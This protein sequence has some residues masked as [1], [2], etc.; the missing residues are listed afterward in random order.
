MI[1]LPLF[2]FPPVKHC[3]NLSLLKGNPQSNLL[4]LDMTMTMYLIV[5]LFLIQMILYPPFLCQILMMTDLSK[6]LFS[7]CLLL[8]HSAQE[9]HPTY[10]LILYSIEKNCSSLKNLYKILNEYKSSKIM[11][12]VLEIATKLMEIVKFMHLNFER[13]IILQ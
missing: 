7:A 12:L 6:C 10:L 5:S 3:A 4:R 13:L 2:I 9:Q 11:Y 1:F 8:S